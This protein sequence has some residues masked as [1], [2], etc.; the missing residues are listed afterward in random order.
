MDPWARFSC[1]RRTFAH[2]TRALIAWAL[3]RLRD[4]SKSICWHKM[5]FA[6]A[7]IIHHCSVKPSILQRKKFGTFKKIHAYLVFRS[8]LYCYYLRAHSSS[9]KNEVQPNLKVGGIRTVLFEEGSKVFKWISSH[10]Y[11]EYE[12]IQSRVFAPV[13]FSRTT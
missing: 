7:T 9:S 6:E 3:L 12:M 1:S 2:S 10:D 8:S 11:A 13:I 5:V 4:I